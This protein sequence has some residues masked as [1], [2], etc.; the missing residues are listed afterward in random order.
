MRIRE[1]LEG[2]SF[3]DLEFVRKDGDET[4]LDYDL[5]E[6][7]AFFLNNDD[8]IYRRFVYPAVHKCVESHGK[9]LKTSP[10][11]F[12]QAAVEGYKEYIKKFPIRELP[13]S[14]EDDLCNEVCGKMHEDV[15][16]DI[17]EG[18]YKD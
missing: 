1:L 15:Y 6:D 4:V 11:V 13:D 10:E 12:K 9:K 18:L 14:L 16:K 5:V 2:K 7:L 8:D 17:G 3:K